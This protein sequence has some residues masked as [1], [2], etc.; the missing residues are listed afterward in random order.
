MPRRAQSNRKRKE[1]IRL[2]GVVAAIL[3]LV[4]LVVLGW[5]EMIK[6]ERWLA[7][8]G[9]LSVVLLSIGVLWAR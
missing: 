2:W 9:T 3:V 8:G 1:K 6:I 4:A 5:G 7:V